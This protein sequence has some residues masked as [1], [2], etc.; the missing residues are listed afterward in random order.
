M[1]LT[2]SEEYDTI[3][4][5]HRGSLAIIVLQ[6]QKIAV[7]YIKER[8]I[9]AALLG[10]TEIYKHVVY[11]RHL[12]S[13]KKKEGKKEKP[14]KKWRDYIYMD[15][16]LYCG[17][18]CVLFVVVTALQSFFS[19]PSSFPFLPFPFFF[20]PKFR[21]GKQTMFFW[22]GKKKKGVAGCR[23]QMYTRVCFH[24]CFF[25]YIRI[26]SRRAFVVQM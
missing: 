11:N 20:P 17:P 16:L 19:A 24:F 1:V 26:S 6:T 12:D 22:G 21:G 7:S 18:F 15:K 8:A 25:N 13:T 3:F 10:P 9:K 2:L 4:P 5:T 14:L 23:F